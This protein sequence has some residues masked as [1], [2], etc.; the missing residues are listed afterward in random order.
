MTTS[1]RDQLAKAGLVSKKPQNQKKKRGPK[2]QQIK[3]RQ[4]ERSQRD[5]EL[6]ALEAHKRNRDR[7]LNA[8]REQQRKAREQAEWV[9]Q[10][11]G[12]HAVKKQTPGDADTAFHFSL[13][14]KIHHLYTGGA[15]RTELASGRL[16]IV[17]FDG[18]YHFLPRGIVEKLQEKIARRTWLSPPDE[19]EQKADSDDPYAEFKVPDDL[20]W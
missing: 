2:S 15:Q 7:E 13:D 3:A 18:Q 6:Q 12:S 14:G 16:G 19:G 20:M 1:L 17:W 9:R 10:L 5:Q 8:Q 4:Q 11:I